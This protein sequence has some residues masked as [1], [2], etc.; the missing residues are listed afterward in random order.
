MR[1][2][3]K[4]LI[5]IEDDQANQLIDKKILTLK[6]IKTLLKQHNI[7]DVTERKLKLKKLN[8]ENKRRI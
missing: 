5:I 7:I 4:F 1:L 8:H 2:E 6:D 3:F